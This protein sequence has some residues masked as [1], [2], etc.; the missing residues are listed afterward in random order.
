MR[1][2]TCVVHLVIAFCVFFQPTF[3]LVGKCQQQGGLESFS[4][5]LK[6]HNIL[7]NEDSLRSALQNK[8]SEV[9]ILAAMKLAEDQDAGSIPLIHAALHTEKV[10]TVKVAFGSALA[11]MGVSEGNDELAAVCEADDL[12]VYVRMDAARHLL[13]SNDGR[14]LGAV[15][16]VVTSQ[17]ESSAKMQAL[18]LLPRF[19]QF[20]VYRTVDVAAGVAAN[21]ADSVPAVRISA[22]NTLVALQ[23]RSTIP[24]LKEQ[25]HREKDA[26]VRDRMT[27]DL[28]ELLRSK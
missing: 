4:D 13:D 11:Q 20:P 2:S 3:C 17:S 5:G 6:R 7:L 9:R 25:I 18:S 15:L 19:K 16:R 23:E 28:S 21:L 27:A 14:C 22:S 8:D 12:K 1:K 24:K 10:P 26:T